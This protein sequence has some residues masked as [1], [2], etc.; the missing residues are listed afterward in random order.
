MAFPPEKTYKI[1]DIYRLP[2]GIRA[3]LID[4]QIYDMAP[5]SRTHQE[6]SF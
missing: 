6:L 4:G 3:E 1:E 2:E 5:P